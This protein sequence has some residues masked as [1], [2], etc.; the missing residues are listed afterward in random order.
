MTLS[1]LHWS[2]RSIAA[3]ALVLAALPAPEAAAQ[4]RTIKLFDASPVTQS[5]PIGQAH[6]AV[7]FGETALVL[8]C[9]AVPWAVVSSDLQGT[10]PVVVDNFLTVDG[11]NVCARWTNG[12]FLGYLGGSTEASLAYTGVPPFDISADIPSG[13]NRV[14]FMLTDFGGLRGNSDVWL[15]TNCFLWTQT[16]ELITIP[17]S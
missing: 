6:E 5:G 8:A 7:V 15:L 11:R 10:G 4:I 1:L 2:V 14:N 17:G 12:C 13:V 3:C 9:P 16:D